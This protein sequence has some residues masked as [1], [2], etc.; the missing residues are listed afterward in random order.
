M[1][2]RTTTWGQPSDRALM[3]LRDAGLSQA[4]IARHFGIARSTVSRRLRRLEEARHAEAERLP[5]AAGR[6]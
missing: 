5:A 6:R 3:R 1:A 2:A 4:E